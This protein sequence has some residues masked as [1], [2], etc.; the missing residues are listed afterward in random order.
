MISKEE[1]RV[2]ENELE[3]INYHK[4]PEKFRLKTKNW[5]KRNPEKVI[6]YR[7]KTKEKMKVYSKAWA[8]KNPDKVKQRSRKWIITHREKYNASVRD[9]AKRN[10]EKIKAYNKKR[11]VTKAWSIKDRAHKIAEKIIMPEDSVCEVCGKR[12]SLD[13]HHV[14]H[15]YPEE[16]VLLCKVCHKFAD[17]QID[18]KVKNKEYEL[19][20]DEL[21]EEEKNASV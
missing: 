11:R 3:R 5:R 12:S 2:R 7:N 16:F 13:K 8:K 14:D 10:P 21:Y 9:Y 15:R 1:K 4:N 17:K 18:W 6:A 20:Y 19:F